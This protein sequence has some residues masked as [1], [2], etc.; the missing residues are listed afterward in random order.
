MDCP[1][2]FSNRIH[3]DGI[4]GG[5]QTYYCLHC[6]KYFTEGSGKNK[7]I[8]VISDTHCGHLWGL[9]PPT[10][11]TQYSE[12]AY[13]FQ[14][15][16]WTWFTN[17]LSLLKPFDMIIANGD[18]I[19]GRGDKSGSTE[20]I[21]ADRMKQAE[22][23]AEIINLVEATDVLMTRGTEYHVGNAEQFED[24]IAERTGAKEIKDLIR[25]KINGSLFDIRHH[26]GRTTV[27]WSDFTAPFKELIL[28]NLEREENVNM[29]IRSHVHKYTYGS[30]GTNQSTITTPG[31]QG[32]TRFGS[33]KCIGRVDFGI[34][35]IEVTPEGIIYTKPVIASLESLKPII[36]N[37]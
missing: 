35:I 2:C 17:T 37:Y 9:T 10:Y 28:A 36:K 13:N 18:M 11:W 26:V 6:G 27:P 22:M 34:V 4:K 12:D 30:I 20:L 15:E 23:A 16:S 21:I 32:H 5:K 14:K 24:N 19:D 3:K 1:I 33:R 31:L 25:F 8:I 29:L 7:R